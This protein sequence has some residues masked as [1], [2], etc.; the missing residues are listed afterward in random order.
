VFQKFLRE[1]GALATLMS[2]SGSTTFAIM[3]N[4]AAAE[5][6]REQFLGFFGRNCWTAV[7][8]V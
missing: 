3:D 7:V 1:F 4:L 8:A 2:G 5:T 6:V